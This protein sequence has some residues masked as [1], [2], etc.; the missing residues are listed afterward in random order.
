MLVPTT[1]DDPASAANRDAWKTL[2]NWRKPFLTA[3]SNRDPIT[4]GA[5]QQFR[6]QV[7]GAL[8]QPH[9]TIRNAGHFLQEEKGP[10]LAQ[11]VIDFINLD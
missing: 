11:V 1:P 7:P 5:D 8:D 9:T 6:E 4:R 2:G 10:E 3:F